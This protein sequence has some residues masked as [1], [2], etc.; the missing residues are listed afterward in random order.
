VVT[1]FH[2]LLLPGVA[3]AAPLGAVVVSVVHRLPTRGRLPIDAESDYIVCFIGL[4]VGLWILFWTPVKFGSLFLYWR[5]DLI[6][7][8]IVAI[9]LAALIGGTRFALWVAPTFLGLSVALMPVT[10]LTLAGVNPPHLRLAVASGLLGA[11]PILLAR[12]FS[13]WW[14]ALRWAVALAVAVAA[15]VLGHAAKLSTT[16]LSLLAAIGAAVGAELVAVLR[17]SVLR[18][19]MM[20]NVT[21]ETWRLLPLA[22]ICA[23]SMTLEGTLPVVPSITASS[24]AISTTL[25]QAKLVSSYR[26]GNGLEVEGWTVKEHTPQNIAVLVVTTIGASPSTVL[27]FPSS[28]LIQWT[29]EPCTNVRTLNVEGVQVTETLYED[30]LN[31]YRWEEFEWATRLG[32]RYQRM[33]AIVASSPSGEPVPLPTVHAS[34]AQTTVDTAEIFVANRHGSCS[35]LDTTTQHLSSRLIKDLLGPELA[36]HHA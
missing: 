25:P 8:A 35:T 1:Q 11:L 6:G 27:S 26:A 28:A 7:A 13:R 32:D 23:G 4:V 10:Q 12:P 3:I 17:G 14:L 5:P 29:A 31:G 16:E 24:P 36:R 20:P 34:S 18:G 21:F 2:S 30:L 19:T 33:T 15:G 9:S 22:V